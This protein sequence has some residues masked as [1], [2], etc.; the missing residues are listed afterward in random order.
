[1]F[2][3]HFSSRCH[4]SRVISA[5]RS[6]ENGPEVETAARW[7]R[8]AEETVQFD[9]PTPVCYWCSVDNFR[10]AATVLKLIALFVALKADR[11]RK[12]LLGGAAWR[13]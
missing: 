6:P 12:L 11:R 1:M 2:C 4:R 10:P 13:K 3:G 8:M 5:F 7:R 9:R